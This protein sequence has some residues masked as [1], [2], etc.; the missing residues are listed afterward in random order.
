MSDESPPPPTS[1]HKGTLG[2]EEDLLQREEFGLAVRRR[3]I[4]SQVV[5]AEGLPARPAG[6]W[7]SAQETGVGSDV[8]G[9]GRK[10]FTTA[11]ANATVHTCTAS[12]TA[13]C[14]AAVNAS[15]VAL[16]R[17]RVAATSS[18]TDVTTTATTTITSSSATQ[19]K[20]SSIMVI[21]P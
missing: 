17:A 8:K 7:D 10:W 11:A 16:P 21:S 14:N 2:Y 12:V 9:Y 18:A 5:T 20:I 3:N 1:P 13:R 4:G 6:T 19:G 15:I